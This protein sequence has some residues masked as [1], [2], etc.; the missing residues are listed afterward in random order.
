MHR[1]E[2]LCLCELGEHEIGLHGRKHLDCSSQEDLLKLIVHMA[3]E[4]LQGGAS[5]PAIQVEQ[6][7]GQYPSCA[8]FVRR[9]SKLAVENIVPLRAGYKTRRSS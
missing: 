1:L 9:E 8:T 6:L 2:F 4:D 3:N 5:E 7:A